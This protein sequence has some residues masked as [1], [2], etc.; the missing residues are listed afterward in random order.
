MGVSRHCNQTCLIARSKEILFIKWYIIKN[1]LIVKEYEED[2]F[3]T[4]NVF[5]ESAVTYTR[6]LDR[7]AEAV[8]N[9]LTYWSDSVIEYF[10]HD[11]IQVSKL[12]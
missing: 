11:V 1:F 5:H 9:K 4:I 8:L 2:T 3:W 7:F 6:R 10:L 12:G